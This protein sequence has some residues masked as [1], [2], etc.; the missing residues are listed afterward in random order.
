MGKSVGIASKPS[1][2]EVATIM[3]QLRAWLGENGYQFVVDPGPPGQPRGDPQAR[4]ERQRHQH[5]VGG[6]EEIAELKQLR[7]H[8]TPKITS[9]REGREKRGL[10]QPFLKSVSTQP[11]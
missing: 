5:A 3:P 11:P 7:E 10:P 4:Q 1:K 2:P 8:C 6:Q 9:S